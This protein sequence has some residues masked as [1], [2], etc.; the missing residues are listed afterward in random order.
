MAGR[1]APWTIA[2]AKHIA[3]GRW[4]SL[5]EVLGVGARAVPPGRAIQMRERD[6]ARLNTGVGPTRPVTDEQRIATGA[7][8]VAAQSL[9]MLIRGGQVERNGDLIR[10]V[11]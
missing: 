3:D 5:D 10:S 6:R 11:R 8:R 1:R 7:R 2:M 9:Q 4:Y